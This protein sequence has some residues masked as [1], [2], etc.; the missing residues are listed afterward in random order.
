MIFS[1]SSMCTDPADRVTEDVAAVRLAA[2]ALLKKQL[3]EHWKTL[4]Y[5]PSIR[6]FENALNQIQLIV[7]MSDEEIA[8]ASGLI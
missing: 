5:G 7:E 3:A 8:E 4:K 6:H 1:Q 2:I